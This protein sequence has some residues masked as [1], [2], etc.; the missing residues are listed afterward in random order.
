MIECK[1][2]GAPTGHFFDSSH[3]RT[4]ERPSDRAQD[5]THEKL[6]QGRLSDARASRELHQRSRPSLVRVNVAPMAAGARGSGGVRGLAL[7]TTA[8]WGIFV[9]KGVAAFV[10]DWQDLWV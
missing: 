5:E 2:Y 8:V 4:V 1:D 3:D 9:D 7:P 10:V 6:H